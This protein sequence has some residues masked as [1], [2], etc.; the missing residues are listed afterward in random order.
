MPTRLTQ[1]QFNNDR[2]QAG[3]INAATDAVLLAQRRLD[4]RTVIGGMYERQIDANTVL[5][6]EA[7]YDVK[8]INQTFTQ[9]TDNVNPN[10]KHYADL[11]HDGR[12]AD[13]PLRSYVGFFVNQMEQ[14]GNTFNNLQDFLAHAGPSHRTAAA[15]S[16]ISAAGFVR[17]W[18]LSRSG[19]SRRDSASSS[20]W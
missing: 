11:H 16:G 5:T 6:L 13:M 7:D 1:S 9:I 3:G 19:P 8:D 12:L 17:N 15:R 18:N 14:E 2:R 20:R 4:R 10:Y